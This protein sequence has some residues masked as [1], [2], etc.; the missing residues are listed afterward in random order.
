M[1]FFPFSVSLYSASTIWSLGPWVEIGDDNSRNCDNL[2]YWWT[3]NI[4]ILATSRLRKPI[5]TCDNILRNAQMWQEDI[6]LVN[7]TRSYNFNL[8][9]L[10]NPLGTTRGAVTV[11]NRIKNRGIKLGKLINTY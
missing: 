6:S 2:S 4:A 10:S 3:E 8:A 7:G 1:N 5:C 9:D 11:W